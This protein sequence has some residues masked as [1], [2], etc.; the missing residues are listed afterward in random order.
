MKRI[1]VILLTLIAVYA[2]GSVLI[3]LVLKADGGNFIA[4]WRIIEPSLRPL[5]N[6]L[7]NLALV[8]IPMGFGGIVILKDDSVAVGIF[9]WVLLLAPYLH[10]EKGYSNKDIYVAGNVLA[11]IAIVIYALAEGLEGIK[12]WLNKNEKKKTA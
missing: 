4:S 2:L 1:I 8:L 6:I 9:V 11:G 3:N 7:L 10:I 12:E 5:G